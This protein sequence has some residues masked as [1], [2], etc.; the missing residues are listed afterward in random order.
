MLDARTDQD[1]FRA[2]ATSGTATPART[3][4]A[5][6]EGR[7]GTEK[8][9]TRRRPAVAVSCD[10]PRSAPPRSPATSLVNGTVTTRTRLS[11]N[12]PASEVASPHSNPPVGEL[13]VPSQNPVAGMSEVATVRV[14]GSAGRNLPAAGWLLVHPAMSADA[15]RAKATSD[16]RLALF[17]HLKARNTAGDH[18]GGAS[19]PGRRSTG[20]PGSVTAA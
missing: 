11:P 10:S 7:Y 1:S 18:P 20:T 6:V 17:A 15:T 19:V 13:D 3:S 4:T 5:G 14:P 16:R 2:A 8:L 12:R 9:S